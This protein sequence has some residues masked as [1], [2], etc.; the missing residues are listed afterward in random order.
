MDR[1]TKVYLE[2]FR[3]EQ[4][5]PVSIDQG[6]LFEHFVNYCVITGMHDEEFDIN[7]I[8][9]GGGNDLTID[10]LA[11]FVNG[12]IVDSVDS[13]EQLLATNGFL[14]VRFV[15]IQSKSGTS[16]SGEEMVGFKDGVLEFFAETLTL[17]ASTRILECREIMS[18]LYEKSGSFTR[19]KPTCELV[20]VTGGSWQNDHQLLTKI[21]RIRNELSET[22]LFEEVSFTPLGAAE[23]QASW[24]NSKETV[25][26]EFV[27]AKKATLGDIAG[28]EESYLGVLPLSEF[29]KVIS[30]EDTG[31]RRHIFVDNVRDYQGDN[32]VNSEI[33]A[34]LATEEGRNRFAVLNNGVTLVA[35]QLRIVGDKF[36]AADYQI[37]NGCQ[38]SHVIYNNRDVLSEDMQIPF[39]VIA[40]DNE[41]VIGA[42]ATATNRQTQVTEEDLYALEGFQKSL[43]SYFE[44]FE[45]K[46]KL[47]YERRSKQFSTTTGIEKVR[48]I[49]KPL[50]IRAFGAMFLNEAHRAARYYAALKGLVGSQIFNPN[51]KLEPYYAAAFAYY[52]LEFLFRNGQ[53]PVVYKP[54]RFHLLMAFRHITAGS[55]MPALTANKIET[56]SKQVIDTLWD[57]SKALRGFQVACSAV[58]TALEGSDLDGN[59]VKVQSFT[60]KV[61]RAVAAL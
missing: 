53:I 60:D 26:A 40:T 51:H 23:I 18:W 9:T 37:V 7:D 2:T 42:I 12:V 36:F 4:S 25:A 47:Y 33:S 57:D 43:E 15:F 46:H 6:A 19:G 49:T 29:L 34:S 17:P 22:N 38:T 44:A 32:P 35:R 45:D 5:L 56:Y 41:E 21:G 20:F 10:G 39:K 31:V 14:D 55:E 58:D 54:A 13:A 11:I 59:T 48:I 50:E 52:K 3:T 24:K 16:F 28:V 1:V 8:H 61:L 27:F 30:D